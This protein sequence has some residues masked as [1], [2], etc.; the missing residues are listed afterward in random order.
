MKSL[1]DRHLTANP[2]ENIV[3]CQYCPEKF[4]K[5]YSLLLHEYKTHVNNEF[6]Y[7]ICKTKFKSPYEVKKHSKETHNEKE[8]NQCD[9]CGKSYGNNRMLVIHIR[10]SHLKM[11]DIICEI[12]G[13]KMSTKCSL[14]KHMLLHSGCKPEKCPYCPKTFARRSVLVIHIRK[15]TGVKPYTCEE[16]GKAFS[17][18]SP[19]VI[20]MRHHTG[21]K[22]YVCELCNVAFVSKN[23]LG[24]HKKNKHS[25]ISL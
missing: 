10:R 25:V 20:H 12:C 18:H 22:P 24:L 3:K 21:V 4:H 11:G 6:I 13:V 23:T 15:H 17:Q 16:C 19:Y 8:E 5:R 7:Y 2:P 1:L 9:F 14:S